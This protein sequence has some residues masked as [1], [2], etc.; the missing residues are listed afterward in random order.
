MASFIPSAII[1]ADKDIALLAYLTMDS[2]PN[3]FMT[4]MRVSFRMQYIFQSGLYFR[5][6]LTNFTACALVN[7]TICFSAANS[8]IRGFSSTLGR[9]II[10]IKGTTLIS[11]VSGTA[12]IR[13][14]GREVVD[15]MVYRRSGMLFLFQY[16]VSSVPK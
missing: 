2:L 8:A 10:F 11:I 15:N 1:Q 12:S 9:G 5:H 13:S 4:A 3:Q 14:N 16:F 7:T 6:S